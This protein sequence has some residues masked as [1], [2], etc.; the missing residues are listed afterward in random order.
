M[1]PQSRPT[2][3]MPLKPVRHGL[4]RRLTAV[5]PRP[6]PEPTPLPADWDRLDPDQRV[7]RLGEW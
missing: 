7:R 3:S 2:A 5:R 1:Y 4:W 6:R